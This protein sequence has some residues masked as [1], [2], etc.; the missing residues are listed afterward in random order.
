MLIRRIV[1]GLPLLLLLLLA[2]AFWNSSRLTGEPK[3]ELT[4]GT[5]GE[6]SNLNPILSTDAASGQVSGL[7][8]Q[9]LM[10]VDEDLN[11]VGELA[12][13]WRLSQRT[14][15]FFS[16]AEEAR[17]AATALQTSGALPDGAQ[18]LAESTPPSVRVELP[19]PGVETSAMLADYI[20]QALPITLLTVALPEGGGTALAAALRTEASLPIAGMARRVFSEGERHLEVT[21]VG[22]PASAQAALQGFLQERGV[23][24]PEISAE[25][26]DTFLA[27][28]EIAFRLRPGIRWQDGASFT[29]DDV[30]FTY[31]AIMNDAVASPRKP[32]FTL[33]QE[34]LTPDPL[35]VIVRYRRPY[36]P[37]L[38][39]WRM[40]IIPAH[41]L[42]PHPPTWWAENFNRRPV[43]TGPYRLA[44]WRTNEFLRLERNP[45]YWRA[46]G[47]WLDSVVFRVLPDP[48]TLRLA[49]ETRMVDFWGVD[50]WAVSS[51]QK[52]P[53]FE[54]FTAPSSSYTY[55]GW[56]LRRP[57]FQDLRVRRALAHAIN[58][59]QM[60]EFLLYGYGVQSTGIFTP[61]MWF[62]DPAVQPI[63]YDKEQARALL[64]EA[65]WSPGADGILVREGER[66]SFT[67][68]TNNA[69][70]VRRDIATLIQDDL[71]QIG[72]EMRIELYE[73][74]V[75]ITRYVNRQDF[76]ALVLGWN[77]PQDDFDQF[78][79]WHSSQTNP[80]Q[81]NMVG[82]KNPTVD[83]LL[84]DIRQEFNRE[85]ILSYASEMQRT[86]FQDQ[87]YLFLF[88]P[89]GTSVMWKNAF[90][91]RRPDGAGGWIDEPVRMTK[92][93][94]SIYLEWFY[95][96]EF[97]ER[98]PDVSGASDPTNSTPF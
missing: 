32:D 24:S 81:L 10:T 1:L 70:E 59:P 61:Q 77:L 91:V 68:I 29:S 7:I 57:L 65:G 85:K 31:E 16:T 80:E 63:P 53:R 89:E 50:P 30:L 13:S 51:F 73:W 52:D 14:T 34:I 20:P 2:V 18:V 17:A 22:D 92:A 76:D 87:P 71:R 41:I 86:I 72:I 46:P 55:V 58:V 75:F 40:S 90:R 26:Q 12:E 74:A 11:P 79:I 83:R 37:A 54:I 48:L 27:E 42:R 15:F 36:S 62:F 96:P 95:R 49:F 82:Y 35:Q 78:Q 60:I 88:V 84:E 25:A 23:A 28:P 6:A 56:N 8:F 5:I 43:G 9:A 44:E 93:G 19:E 21:V 38:N 64:A 39:S 69:N 3:N 45:D 97:A 67:L 94:W 4:F 66:F 98:L 47:P 33:I